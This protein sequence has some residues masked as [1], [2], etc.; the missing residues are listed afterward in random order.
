MSSLYILQVSYISSII[1]Y[2]D[3]N[4]AFGYGSSYCLCYGSRLISS[5]LSEIHFALILWFMWCDINAMNDVAA[6]IPARS[7]QRELPR[8]SQGPQPATNLLPSGVAIIQP[9]DML[10]NFT[11]PSETDKRC[12]NL[13]C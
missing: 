10:W 11:D 3:A 12:P 1:S 2:S 4:V 13:S 6:S 5:L 7:D 9:K 8:P